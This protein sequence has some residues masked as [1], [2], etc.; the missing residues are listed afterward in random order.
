MAAG[1]LELS[2]RKQLAEEYLQLLEQRTGDSP[3]IIDK[4]T[5]NL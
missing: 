2:T 3:Q 5:T 1:L 4:T